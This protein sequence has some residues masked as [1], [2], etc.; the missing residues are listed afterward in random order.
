[1]KQTKQKSQSSSTGFS[2]TDSE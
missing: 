1:T 2:F